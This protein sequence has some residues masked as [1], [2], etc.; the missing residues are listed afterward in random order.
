[1]HNLERL[2]PICYIRRASQSLKNFV[3]RQCGAK[4]VKQPMWC[5]IG[6]AS[7]TIHVH[8]CVCVS[9]RNAHFVWNKKHA[10]EW[11]AWKDL[12]NAR[13]ASARQHHRALLSIGDAQEM[14]LRS[15]VR[16]RLVECGELSKRAT[17][18]KQGANSRAKSLWDEDLSSN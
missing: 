4:L 15:A 7:M 18:S 11:L 10:R 13:L 14:G 2:N 12:E 5:Q 17:C 1:M 3:N 9:P 16:D 8:L 6:E